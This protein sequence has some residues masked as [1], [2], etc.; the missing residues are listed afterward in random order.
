MLYIRNKILVLLL[1]VFP[2]L[3]YAE[4][5]QSVEIH[6]KKIIKLDIEVF[7]VDLI[8]APTVIVL[9]GCGGVDGHH[10][11]W[12]KQ[13]NAW[14]YNSVLLDSFSTRYERSVC[15][16]PFS[17]TPS[18]RAVDLQFTAKWIAG[19][20]WGKAKIGVIGFSHGAWTTLY[21]V[22]KNEIAREVSTTIISSAVAF[23]P[24]CDNS[25]FFDS[26]AIPIQIHSGNLDNWA[27]STLCT[28]LSRN[29]NITDNFFVYS[30][31]HHGF[32]RSNTN[33]L[34]A[35]HTLRSNPDANILARSRVKDFLNKTLSE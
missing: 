14:G 23:Y 34:V 18:Q 29:W 26:P 10:R 15:Q 25:R 12:A 27:P 7:K 17:V 16:K 3:V 30:D 31:S 24:Y 9:H 13:L 20:P 1:C 35:G 33:I 8:N 19:Q 21:A 11:D 6:N 4:S 28:D 22:S 32:D 2:T 5:I